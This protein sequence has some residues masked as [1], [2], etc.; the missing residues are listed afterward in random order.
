MTFSIRLATPHDLP[1]IHDIYNAE[2]S[3]GVA[4]WNNQPQDLQYYEQWFKQLVDQ[5]FPLFVIEDLRSKVVAGFAEYSTFRNISGFLQTVEHAVYIAPE[6]AKQGL[7]K[8]LL[9]HL[10]EHAQHHQIKVMVAAIDHANT[11]S[12]ALHQKLGF[13]Q[14]GYMPQVGQKFGEW[15]DLVLMQLCFEHNVIKTLNISE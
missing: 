15:R 10:I 14:T 2:I 8:R 3:N 5:G 13:I 11:A 12:I 7:G 6:F 4:T 9:Q 1:R